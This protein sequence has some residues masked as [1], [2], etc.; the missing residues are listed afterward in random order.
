MD[1]MGCFCVL[2]G[3]AGVA[4]VLISKFEEDIHDYIPLALQSNCRTTLGGNTED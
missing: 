2:E 3:Y 4:M 1:V